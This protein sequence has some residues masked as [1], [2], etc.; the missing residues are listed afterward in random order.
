[1]KRD[2]HVMNIPKLP[3]YTAED[4][5]ERIKNFFG[6][7]NEWKNIDELIPSKFKSSKKFKSTGKAGIFAGSLELVKEGNIKIKQNKLFDNLYIRENNE[8]RK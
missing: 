6:K 7:L 2:F 3:V 8:E 4:G 1:M 5:I